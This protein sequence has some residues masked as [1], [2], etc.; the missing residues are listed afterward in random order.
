[1]ANIYN[2]YRVRVNCY[3][4]AESGY[5]MMDGTV[6]VWR[7]LARCFKTEEDANSAITVLGYR[8]TTCTPTHPGVRTAY[9]CR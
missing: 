6:R 9:V 3:N 7:Q 8:N 1:M 5:L 2:G 4:D